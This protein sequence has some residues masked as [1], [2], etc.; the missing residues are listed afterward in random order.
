M[1][2]HRSVTDRTARGGDVANAGAA[3]AVDAVGEREEG[4]GAQHH[5]RPLR[6]E[7]QLLLGGTGMTGKA[8][9]W[10]PPVWVAIK[11]RIWQQGRQGAGD[12]A[13]KALKKISSLDKLGWLPHSPPPRMEPV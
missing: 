8:I 13:S 12:S 9:E 2:P 10:I 5:A 3:G 6:H 4:V 7:V 1:R 11:G